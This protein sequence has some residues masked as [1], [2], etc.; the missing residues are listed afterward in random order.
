MNPHEYSLICDMG[1][2][3]DAQVFRDFNPY[4]V[5]LKMH[6]F[7]YYLFL[8]F[9]V[10]VSFKT[11]SWMRRKWKR[12]DSQWGN[13]AGTLYLIYLISFKFS[14]HNWTDEVLIWFLF[15]RLSITYTDFGV[16]YKIVP[17]WG[18][19]IIAL[20]IFFHHKNVIYR[21]NCMNEMK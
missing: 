19:P 11:D 9:P 16:N 5:I 15:E 14:V 20:K 17:R 18:P 3:S 6:H 21:S 10:S 4:R 8:S 2:P 12:L 7:I 1:I 13:V